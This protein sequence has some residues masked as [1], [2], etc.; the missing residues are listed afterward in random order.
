MH[1]FA[2]ATPISDIIVANGE[3]DQ[4]NYGLLGRILRFVL[5][6]Y[7][8]VAFILGLLGLG[9]SLWAALS[10]LLQVV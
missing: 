9:N 6:G 10:V 2:S 8:P 3:E 5:I 4:G 7:N 1:S